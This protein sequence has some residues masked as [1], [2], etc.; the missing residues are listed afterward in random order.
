MVAHID[1]LIDD[2]IGVTQGSPE[3]CQHA[4][5]CILHAIDK[6]FAQSGPNTPNQIETVSKKKMLKGDGGWNQHKEILGWMLNMCQGTME[7]TDWYKEHVLQIFVD[8]QNKWHFGVKKWQHII[9]ELHFMGAAIPG[10]VGLS[11]AMQLGLSYIKKHLICITSYLHDHHLSDFKMLTQNF[12]TQPNAHLA[13]VMPDYLFTIGSI[14]TAKS[15]MG[16]VLFT[17]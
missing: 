17:G 5:G 2:F 1:I 14:N 9:G 11:G 10:C 12:A 16:R 15:G 4:H 3:H 7:L 13:E 8:L 6:V